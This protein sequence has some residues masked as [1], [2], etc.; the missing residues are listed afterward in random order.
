MR[1]LANALRVNSLWVTRPGATMKCMT[2]SPALGRSRRAG[3]AAFFA[4]GF[5]F[6]S[7]TTRLPQL[8]GRVGVHALGQSGLLLMM[9][10]L[11]GGGSV[12]AEKL[13]TSWPSARVLRVALI[14]IGVGVPVIVIAPGL[15]VLIAGMAI[16]GI[17]LGM[18]DASTNMQ[19]VAIEARYARPILPSFH[20]AWTV[21][22]I[23]A[24]ALTLAMAN[25]PWTTTA[26]VA[27]VPVVVAAAPF[28]PRGLA[29]GSAPDARPAVPPEPEETVPAEAPAVPWR[30]IVL[31]GIAMVLFYMVDTAATTWGPTYL[32]QT[33]AAPS[34][35]LALAT[36]PYLVASGVQRL[37]GD[38][39]VGR[40]GPVAVVRVG[41][42]VACGALAVVVFSP[43]WL[44][45]VAGFALLGLGVAVVAPLS[46]SA[47]ATI[48][49]GEGL[50]P[51]VRQARIDAVIGR[52]NQFNYV[53]ALL[54]AVM[55]G[56]VG[57]G[58][59]RWGFALPMVLVLGLIPLA[60]YFTGPT[61]EISR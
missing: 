8:M 43:G 61:A 2:V 44:V 31:V 9:V 25:L 51:V 45:A 54:G 48:A 40:L 20:G 37:A 33:M 13:A 34:N 5:T 38:R 11:A 52:F 23:V 28:L 58:N 29:V 12:V 55:T 47:A 16:Y 53:G 4:Q 32:D 30:P 36:L 35:L 18:V 24:S 6:I 7:L 1:K 41:A 27:V 14:A 60:R 21:G 59:L 42:V 56:L 39:L 17:G 26:L 15:G 10:L 49:G 22:G 50:D 46:Y 57:A 19:A 3:A